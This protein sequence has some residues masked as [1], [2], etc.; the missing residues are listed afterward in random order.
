MHKHKMKKSQEK[1]SKAAQRPSEDRILYGDIPSADNG[2]CPFPKEVWPQ[3]DRGNYYSA[4]NHIA[5]GILTISPS[6]L[7]T[8]LKLLFEMG[9]K[10]C[11][12]VEKNWAPNTTKNFYYA[13]RSG[14]GNFKDCVLWIRGEMIQN[15]KI[16]KFHE[17]DKINAVISHEEFSP[18]NYNAENKGRWVRAQDW[19]RPFNKAEGIITVGVFAGYVFKEIL[20]DQNAKPFISDSLNKILIRTWAGIADFETISEFIELY[21]NG[22]ICNDRL[23]SHGDQDF[24]FWIGNDKDLTKLYEFWTNPAEPIISC[25]PEHFILRMRGNPGSA[26]FIVWLKQKQD[27]AWWIGILS[28]NSR[29]TLQEWRH[30]P[31]VFKTND[32]TDIIPGSLKAMYANKGKEWSEIN[33]FC[34]KEFPIPPSLPKK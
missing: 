7:L 15:K 32:D 29:I 2:Y 27:L 13:I 1:P 11:A 26:P 34:N 33:K 23:T 14:T 19:V 20:A 8:G 21:E 18:N 10:Y 30:V 25:R 28:H 9:E 3:V 31:S 24:S 16:Q 4:L 17:S 12:Y 22:L 6:H 5:D